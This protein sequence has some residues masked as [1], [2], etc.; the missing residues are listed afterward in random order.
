[1][2]HKWN[3]ILAIISLNGVVMNKIRKIH[4][5]A[6]I[7]FL[8]PLVL[9]VLAGICFRE[10]WLLLAAGLCIS[11]LFGILVQR[12]ITL[13]TM[14]M[15]LRKEMEHE[16]SEA[17]EL[18]RMLYD[19]TPIGINTF[20]E[21][22]NFTG[23]NN[24]LSALL[25]SLPRDINAQYDFIGD[26]SPKYQP[27]GQLSSEK[28]IAIKNKTLNG[29]KLLFEWLLKSDEDEYIP[30]EVTTTRIK[31]KGK[32]VGLSYIYDLRRVKNMEQVIT[33]LKSDL[34]ESKISIM[35]SQIKPHFL[36]NA[37]SAIAQ[38]CGEDPLKAKR[39]TIDFA[40]Y[41][42]NN[43]ESLE[44]E[45][46]ISFEKELDHVKSYL[47]LEKAIYGDALKVVYNIGDVRFFLPPLSV[48]PI[49][50]NAVKHGIGK[51]EGGGTVTITVTEEKGGYCINI[52]DDGAG[53]DADRVKESKDLGIGLENVK[54]R[55]KEQCGGTLTLTGE[56][57]IGTSVNI[58]IPKGAQ[59]YENIGFR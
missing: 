23:G 58:Y 40:A 28:A 34:T 43:M 35:L 17:N 22:L 51:K 31:H 49:V 47:N 46:L 8:L 42:R 24:F 6:I 41:L 59:N 26:F 38:L 52:S 48:Q 20:D 5:K 44:N 4:I 25:G 2:A 19:N 15:T 14:N 45:G 10:A 7:A 33:Q 39:A 12:I 13:K 30:C 36:Y 29:E 55:I 3:A 37:L 57:G 32:D 27:D 11:L 18:L 53:Y 9:F 56:K 21:D 50:E 1:M 54:K 16:I